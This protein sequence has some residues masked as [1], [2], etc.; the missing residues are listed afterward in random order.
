MPSS[1]EIFSSDLASSLQFCAPTIRPR[2]VMGLSLLNFGA[3]FFEANTQPPGTRA[4]A[5]TRIGVSK[6]GSSTLMNTSRLCVRITCR[7]SMPISLCWK[8]MYE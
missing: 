6:S 3:K 7:S 1:A 4:K 2:P 8:L 5:I